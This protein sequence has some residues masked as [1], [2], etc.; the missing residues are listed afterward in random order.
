MRR[1]ASRSFAFESV[2]VESVTVKS[3]ASSPRGRAEALLLTAPVLVFLASVALVGTLLAFFLTVTHRQVEQAAVAASRNEATI[4]A[5]RIEATLRRV[6]A[7]A[8][9][10]ADQL[11]D[12]DWPR[13]NVVAGVVVP[14]PWLAV[15]GAE[16]PE[17][18]SLV[19]HDATGVLALS[20]VARPGDLSVASRPL[21]AT[22]RALARH[23]TGFSEVVASHVTGKPNVFAF[24]SILSASGDFRGVIIIPIDLSYF[25]RL[26]GDLD[27][28][29]QGLVNIRRAEDSRLVVRWP[30]APGTANSEARTTPTFTRI[31]SGEL[32][33]HDRLTSGVDGIDRFIAFERV[34]DF[35]FYVVVGRSAAEVFGPWQLNAL[36]TTG[37]AAAALAI[38][39]VLLVHFRRLDRARAESEAR[40]R[41]A[42]DD[43][44]DVLCRYLPDSTLTF[45]NASYRRCFELPGTSVVGKKWLDLLPAAERPAQMAGLAASA[46]TSERTVREFWTTGGDGVARCLQ[47]NTTPHFDARGNL[48]ELQS[49]GRDITEAKAAAAELERHRADLAALVEERTA[50][51]RAA[52][53]QAEAASVAKS[54]FLANMSHEIRTPLN[55]IT[56]MVHILKRKRLGAAADQQLDIIAAAGQHLLQ[57]IN[58]ILDLSKI[59]AGRLDLETAPVDVTEVMDRVVAVLGERAAAK[60]LA[61]SVVPPQ[62]ATVVLGDGTR[63]QQALLNYVTN[64]IKFTASGAITLQAE[65]VAETDDHVELRFSVED[66]G[67]GI[68][69]EILPR[70]FSPFEQADS[71]YTRRFGGTG[72]GLAITR[73]LAQLMGGDAGAASAPGVGSTFWFTARLAKADGRGVAPPVRMIPS[74]DGALQREFA[75]SRILLVEDE[76]INAEIAAYLLRTVGLEVDI[77]A[78]GT[79]AVAMAGRNAYAAILMDV[80]LPQMD[81]LE[82][83][84]RIRAHAGAVRVPILALTANAF[85]EDMANCIAAG[86]NDF[87]AKP[88]QPA[89]LYD[90]LLRWL[91]R[92]RAAETLPVAARPVTAGR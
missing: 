42:V 81:G 48:V 23:E 77:V 8:D 58:A 13:R 25:R 66:T 29:Q 22:A 21:F 71:S 16:F 72:L 27:V 65:V 33:G 37:L 36:T 45:V 87:I 78:D 86:M 26:F 31:A 70:L 54:S 20:S 92:G 35:P 59:E 4:L 76:P 79:E 46:G 12:G 69:P 49:V 28:G 82:A 61:L 60:G 63:L 53:E 18:V 10:I 90:I 64:A 83:T 30:E 43:Q 89:T 68:A 19:V 2:A 3:A 38:L 47:W 88:M 15:L 80:Q 14:D 11:A 34:K 73:R 56:G 17:V 75:G 6:K 74:A 24:Q 7:T 84:R 67:V 62:I 32:R 50:Q 52:K 9:H 55:A 91:R 5:T 57:V 40:Y 1:R 39:A 41:M 85:A 44:A 51:L